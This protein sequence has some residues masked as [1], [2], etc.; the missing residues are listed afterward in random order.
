[1]AVVSSHTLNSADGTHAGGTQAALTMVGADEHRLYSTQMDDGGRLAETVNLALGD[2]NAAY[3]LVFETGHYWEKRL[4][5]AV[6]V[7][8][9]KQIVLQ[10]EIP[11]PQGPDHLPIIPSPNGCSTRMSG[12]PMGQV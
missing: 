2:P 9:T 8:N 7:G 6:A 11:G 3:E 4:D 12:Q 1:M 5:P 10:F